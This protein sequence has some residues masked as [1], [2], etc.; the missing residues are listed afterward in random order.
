VT[1]GAGVTAASENL[2]FYFSGMRAA[3]WG[4]IDYNTNFA[5][6]PANTLIEIDMST[7]RSE[8]WTNNTLPSTVP[9]RANAELVWIPVSTQ[10]VLVAIGGVYPP[11]EIWPY[12]LNTSQTS[13]STAQSPGF[14]TSLP[15][16][17]I[18]SQTWY[19]QNTTGTA[20]G[21]LTEF[22]SVVAAAN[23]SS[24]YNV[25]IYGGY[26]G[27][28]SNDGPSDDVWILSI[29]SFTWI[30]A[31]SG[32]ASHGRSA[33][34]CVAPYPDQMFVIGGVHQ[35]QAT[36][37]DGVIQVFNLNTLQFQ[38]TYTPSTWSPYAVP[39]VVTAVIGGNA[40]G[41]STK[42]AA[43]SDHNLRDLFQTK[44]TQQITQYYPYP[45]NTTTSSSPTPAPGP[46]SSGTKKWVAPVVGVICGLVGL[47]LIILALLLFRRRRLLH[48]NSMDG[49]S[50]TGHNT[51]RI[52]RWVNGMQNNPEPKDDPS[53]T[54]TEIEETHASSPF[55]G[56]LAGSQ[57][58]EMSAVE[59]PPKPPVELAT[60]YH[61]EAHASYPKSIDYAYGPAPG[62]PRSS[63]SASN[64]E[65]GSSGSRGVPSPYTPAAQP[66]RPED[67]G[68]GGGAATE[69]VSAPGSSSSPTTPSHSPYLRP[70]ERAAKPSP[71]IP[72]VPPVPASMDP[73]ATHTRN[74]SSTS[75]GV[76]ALPPP[77]KGG[78]PPDE[79]RRRSLLLAGL[80][81]PSGPHNWARARHEGAAHSA[82]SEPLV[83][84]ET[85]TAPMGPG[86][87]LGQA[88]KL[89][90]H[91][92]KQSSF[93][94]SLDEEDEYGH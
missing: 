9:P 43:W 47:T 21:Q 18:A 32:T 10:G 38:D 14:M 49:S 56:E 52:I 60:P 64:Y 34:K 46:S 6:T 40:Q 92:A 2:G 31:Y 24:S 81:N 44:Y 20:P 51:N 5:D 45:V 35:S 89:R 29:P 79:D 26:D 58:Y 68:G 39:S 70:A 66:F 12:G 59:A 23:D 1:N 16:Y 94:E 63:K 87:W 36:C 67:V 84:P 90:T 80:P 57:R 37:I 7:M 78:V 8:K 25:Y 74:T 11:E 88:G 4:P 75:S 62:Q 41:G 82:D 69:V 15:I 76:D 73:R 91:T 54:S 53:V 22:C 3:D 83:S 86:A 61:F 27:L 71:L 55:T 85:P 28:D 93:Q 50:S 33:H 17:D 30:K 19:M 77:A 42:T 65:N 13:Q 72:P 48:R